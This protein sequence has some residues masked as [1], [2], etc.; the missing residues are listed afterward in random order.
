MKHTILPVFAVLA[1]FTISSQAAIIVVPT[2]VSDS[3][4]DHIIDGSGLASTL[5]T[6]DPVPATYPQHQVGDS[7]DGNTSPRIENVAGRT[8]MNTTTISNLVFNLGGA[9]DLT[10]MVL[11]N[12]SERWTDGNGTSYYNDR[13]IGAFTLEFSTDGTTF[14]TPVSFNATRVPDGT[15]SG[16]QYF[17]SEAI[18]FDDQT[19]ITHVRMNVTSNFGGDDS[20]YV[21]MGE[22]VFTAVPEPESSSAILLAFCGLGFLARR[23]RK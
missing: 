11:W 21:G 12:Y 5:A 15:A 9:Y 18:D 6:G 16:L 2:G 8:P 14:S 17:N 10:G 3:T 7:S 22:V 19:G 20:N 23:R 1:A 13:G 4:F